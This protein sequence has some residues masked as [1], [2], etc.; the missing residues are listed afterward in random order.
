MHSVMPAAADRAIAVALIRRAQCLLRPSTG[1]W[2]QVGLNGHWP[3]LVAATA[4]VC[5]AVAEVVCVRSGFFHGWPDA[6]IDPL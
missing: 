4:I 1:Q 2:Q 6:G 5:S 3:P